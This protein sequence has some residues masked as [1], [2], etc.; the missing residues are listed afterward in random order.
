MRVALRPAPP[1][2]AHR[3][4]PLR[5]SHEDGSGLKAYGTTGGQ[6]FGRRRSKRV[7]GSFFKQL[8][9]GIINCGS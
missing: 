2:A 1:P 6:E 3:V 8:N 5:V 7:V 9:L 4:D